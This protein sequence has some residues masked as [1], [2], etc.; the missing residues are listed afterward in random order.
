MTVYSKEGKMTV[1]KRYFRN[2]DL[3]NIFIC[4]LDSGIELHSP[5]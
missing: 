5:T 2:I 1:K 3:F 4:D